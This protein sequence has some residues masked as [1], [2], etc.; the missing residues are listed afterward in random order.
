[1]AGRPLLG[2]PLTAARDAELE[3]VVVAK[4]RSLLPELV[5]RVLYEADQPTH[6]LC[7]V[8]RALSFAQER[9]G[10]A[11][12]VVV[13]CDMPFVTGALL[14]WLAELEGAAVASIDGRLQ[15]TLG[16]YV[17]SDLPVLRE[18]LAVER[19]LRETVRALSPRIV[20][21][22]DLGRFGDPARLCFNVNCPR[23]LQVAEGWLSRPAP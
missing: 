20:D 1:M 15:P 18:A 22:Q 8:V 9:S 3:A 4:R 23:G 16:R 2:Y 5:A 17:P 7:G 21:E 10:H 19:P 14:A 12:V 11:A 6:P 13:A